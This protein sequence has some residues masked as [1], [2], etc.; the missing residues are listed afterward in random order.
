MPRLA[1][2]EIGRVPGFYHGVGNPGP[3]TLE[4]GE[5]LKDDYYINETGPALW[6]CTGSGSATTST[7]AQPSVAGQTG[8]ALTTW[9]Q[10]ATFQVTGAAVS[11]VTFSSLNGTT[12]LAYRLVGHAISDGTADNI[13]VQPNADA[14]AAHYTEQE[15]FGANGAAGAGAAVGT[16]AGMDFCLTSATSGDPSPSELVMPYT[17]NDQFRGFITTAGRTAAAAANLLAL[18]TGGVWLDNSTNITS[19]KILT[20][21]GNAHIG[22]GS[23]FQLWAIRAVHVISIP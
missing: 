14:T 22:I 12:D 3:A 13:V 23:Y 20:T 5:Y 19:L 8:V 18:V 6:V 2:W 9:A 15:L 17:K 11:S 10:I 4:V 21:S 1:G 16:Q 7:W